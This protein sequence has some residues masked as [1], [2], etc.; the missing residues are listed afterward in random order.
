MINS[1]PIGGHF[2]VYLKV[3]AMNHIEVRRDS[4]IFDYLFQSKKF[5]FC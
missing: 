3:L 4:K 5:Q 1:H 2:I